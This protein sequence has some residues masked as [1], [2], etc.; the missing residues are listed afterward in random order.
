MRKIL[1]VIILGYMMLMGPNAVFSTEQIVISAAELH[2]ARSDDLKA[3]EALYLG[4]TV[5]VKGIVVSKGIS[6]YL[7]PNVVLSSHAGGPELIICV[8]PRLD[9][10]KLSDFE[11]GQSVTFSGRV[12][13]LTQR[14]VMKECTVQASN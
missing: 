3:A 8:L 10:G 2:K 14:V 9:A 12:Q 1:A 7:T 6:K 13:S 4:K 11:P 5:L